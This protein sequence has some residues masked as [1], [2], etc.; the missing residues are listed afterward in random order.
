MD[1]LE[2]GH[3]LVPARADGE[4]AEQALAFAVARG[5]LRAW[6]TFFAQYAP[7]AYRFAYRHVDCNRADAE[8]LC[9]EIMTAAA[10]SL[11]RFDARRGNLDLWLLGLARH[12]LAHFLRRRRPEQPVPL[13]SLAEEA[14]SE[15]SS[16]AEAL[17]RD[18]VNRALASLSPRQSSL[19]V[20]KYVSGYTMEELARATQSSVKAVE[21]LLSRARAA[22]RTAFEGLAED[23]S[24]GEK[25]G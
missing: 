7:W 15:P 11:H 10:R 19:L 4:N 9:S 5:D 13:D 24:G 8:D 6:E 14:S 21:S 18:L 20:G 22:F 25:H 3:S 1:S 12:R 2:V 17:H 23:G 16:T